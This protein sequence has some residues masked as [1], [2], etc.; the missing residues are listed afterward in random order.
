M[1]GARADD[2]HEAVI[3]AL[4]HVLHRS[5]DDSAT[6]RDVGSGVR[7][8]RIGGRTNVRGG[9]EARAGPHL[10]ALA[11]R[12][13]AVLGLAGEGDLLGEARGREKRPHIPDAGVLGAL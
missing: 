10:H 5:G 8:G 12:D 3:G 13:D 11:G 7:M 2:H 6:K 9:V 1:D 4:Q